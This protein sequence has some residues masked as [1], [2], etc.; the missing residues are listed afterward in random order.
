MKRAGG[1]AIEPEYETSI[2]GNPPRLDLVDRP[3]IVVMLAVFPVVRIDAIQ[4]AGIWVLEAN[5]D[6]LAAAVGG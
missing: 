2:H 4:T 6:L 5:E 3:Q 1:V